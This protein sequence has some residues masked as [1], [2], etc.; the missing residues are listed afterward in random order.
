ML[1]LLAAIFVLHISTVIILLVATIHNA[2]WVTNTLSTDIWKTCN[3][4]NCSDIITADESYLQAIQATAVLSC[5]FAI[6]SLFVF[7]AQLFTLAKGQRFTFTGIF[8]MISCLCIMVAASIYTDQFHKN[9]TGSYG[10]SYILAWIGF[11]FT[12]IS[13]IVYFVLRKKTE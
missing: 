7:I 10:S 13:S 2:W 4:Y 5:I 3:E 1:V 11:A 8:H 6:I 12:F 9:D